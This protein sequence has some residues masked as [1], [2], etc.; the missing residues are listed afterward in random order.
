[1]VQT[2][3]KTTEIPLFP[4]VDKVDDVLVVQ[5]VLV[6]QGMETIEI[7]QFAD[8]GENRCDPWNP[9]RTSDSLGTAL[10]R[11][12]ARAEI[13]EVV[14]IRAPLPAESPSSNGV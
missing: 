9:A 3:Q 2:F 4:Y 6:P 7:P 14:E 13:V 12:V 10:V 8:R 1:M 5:V 11:H